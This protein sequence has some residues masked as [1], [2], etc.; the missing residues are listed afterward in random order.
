[1]AW[2]RTL[3]VL[4][5][6][7]GAGKT[8]AGA[9]LLVGAGAGLLAYDMVR[10]RGGKKLDDVQVQPLPDFLD[11]NAL[12]QQQAAAMMNPDLNGPLEGRGPTEWRDRFRPGQAERDMQVANAAQPSLSGG[13][14]VEDLGA[15][16][17]RT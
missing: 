16:A 17:A 12:S 6:A 15:I 9:S 3:E 4:S 13:Q 7:K 10:D 8:F 5:K 1:M 11:I 2:E 14:T